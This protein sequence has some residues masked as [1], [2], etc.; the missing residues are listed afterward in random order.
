MISWRFSIGA[1]GAAGAALTGVAGV[2]GEAAE[3]ADWILENPLQTIFIRTTI[4][5]IQMSPMKTTATP[6]PQTNA[7]LGSA[8]VL[9]KAMTIP[10]I[11]LLFEFFD[12][13]RI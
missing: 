5:I 7:K 12:I 3:G 9:V 6:S 8:G 4:P 11:L 2:A 10:I 13:F 1:D